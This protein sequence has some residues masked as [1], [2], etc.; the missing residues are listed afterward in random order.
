M[1]LLSL[2]KTGQY[3]SKKF[4]ESFGDFETTK[5]TAGAHVCQ[6]ESIFHMY[7]LNFHD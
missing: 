3:R 2:R 6:F 5:F 1:L 4:D 7:D